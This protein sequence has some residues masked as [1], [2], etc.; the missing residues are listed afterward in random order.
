MPDAATT[1]GWFPE[2]TLLA[3]YRRNRSLSGFSIGAPLNGSGYSTNMPAT[4]N[5]QQGKR[6]GRISFLNVATAFSG[7]HF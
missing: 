4:E 3:G 1:P 6:Q 2:V 5:V 7:R